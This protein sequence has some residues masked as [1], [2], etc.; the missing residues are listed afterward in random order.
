MT[1]W[2]GNERASSYLCCQC[3]QSFRCG[4]CQEN[5]CPL[6]VDVAA[7]SMDVAH[8]HLSS[9]RMLIQYH[10]HKYEPGTG[11]FWRE[12][13]RGNTRQKK[14]QPNNQTKQAMVY[15]GS[16]GNVVQKRTIWRFSIITDVLLGTFDI[17]MLFFR[18]ISNP[19][20]RDRNQSNR[21][22]YVQR[23]GVRRPRGGPRGSNI[24]TGTQLGSTQH[25]IGGG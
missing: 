2:E 21:T 20:S 22:T 3:P 14:N 13:E 19:P 8:F 7:S 18:T 10:D 16:D 9:E 23:Q 17:V 6:C 12:F 4:E 24:R 1:K 11:H 15:V 5:E 25:P